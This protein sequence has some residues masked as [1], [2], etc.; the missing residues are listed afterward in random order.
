MHDM[1]NGAGHFPLVLVDQAYSS[2][3]PAMKTKGSWSRK[4]M[5][6]ERSAN[7]LAVPWDGIRSRYQRA[8]RLCGQ[9]YAT[10]GPSSQ[11]R[12]SC[13]SFKLKIHL[14]G[15]EVLLLAL[16]QHWWLWM[17]LAESWWWSLP[18]RGW[19]IA[20]GQK[21]LLKQWSSRNF[22]EI[23]RAINGLQ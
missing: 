8:C 13:F 4:G 9:P 16:L 3:T 7:V 11:S 10:D 2:E 22:G 15:S 14:S 17:N 21:L 6:K 5:P 1:K 12:T 23:Y 18:Y 19:W 20:T